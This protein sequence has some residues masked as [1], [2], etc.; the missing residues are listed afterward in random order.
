MT[1]IFLLL[2]IDVDYL[3]TGVLRTL[4]LPLALIPLTILTA[5][6]SGSAGDYRGSFVS[7]DIAED[8]ISAR[9]DQVPMMA[10]LGRI[11]SFPRFEVYLNGRID[12]TVS[13]DL[14]GLSVRHGIKQILNDYHYVLERSVSFS[15]DRT[16]EFRYTLWIHGDQHAASIGDPASLPKSSP[17]AGDTPSNTDLL[18]SEN[19]DHRLRALDALGDESSNVPTAVQIDLFTPLLWDPSI[20]VREAATDSISLI[21]EPYAISLVEQQLHDSSPAVRE[22]AI[23]A[24]E[25]L[26][27]SAIEPL[28]MVMHSDRDPNLRQSAVFAIAN[29]GGEAAARAL[30]RAWNRSDSSLRPV[31][32]EALTWMPAELSEPLVL[33]AMGHRDAATRRLAVYAADE[34]AT[35]KLL[36]AISGAVSDDDVG[37]RDAAREVFSDCRNE[38]PP[39]FGV[40]ELYWHRKEPDVLRRHQH[41]P[42]G[43]PGRHAHA[44]PHGTLPSHIDD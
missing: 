29:I 43:F 9:L 13:C 36:A 7:I 32:L 41:T 28:S 4:L 26:G 24:L 25:S 37:V 19:P 35:D 17:A 2:E 39:R 6:A 8:K 18:S 27:I 23:D 15:G 11:A 44:K 33:L 42:I 40:G 14:K 1:H 38:Q 10:V 31:I 5:A 3:F 20:A 16:E 34:I 22:T 30:N 21:D 12:S